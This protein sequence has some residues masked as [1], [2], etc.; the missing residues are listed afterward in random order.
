MK[1][2]I[3][4]N[5]SLE[6]GAKTCPQCGMMFDNTPADGKMFTGSSG[7]DVFLG[8]IAGLFAMIMPVA[9]QYLNV[10]YFTTLTP[11]FPSLG[12]GVWIA[13]IIAFFVLKNSRP[14][15]ARG[16][17]YVLLFQLI[18]A[19]IGVILLLGAFVV[20]LVGMTAMKK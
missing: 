19:A 11:I 9:I 4:C 7:G 8:V 10:S 1:L 18:L 2:C 16:L 15:F 14:H 12:M 6:P 3:N 20:C 17:K 5:H 13:S